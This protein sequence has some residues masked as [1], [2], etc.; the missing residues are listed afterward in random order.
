MN[1]DHQHNPEAL[2]KLYKETRSQS[3]TVDS[4]VESTNSTPDDE[5]VDQVYQR[6]QQTRN[7]ESN[8]IDEIMRGIADEERSAQIEEQPRLESADTKVRSIDSQVGPFSWLSKLS[9][10]RNDGTAL[11]FVLPVVAAAMCAFII[12]P[13]VSD[14]V[15]STDPSLDTA[16]LSPTLAPYVEPLNAS[17]LGFS[18]LN[19]ERGNAFQY[20]VLAADLQVLKNS[21]GSA[22]QLKMLVQSYLADVAN[23]PEEMNLAAQQIIALS[24]GNSDAATHSPEIIEGIDSLLGATKKHVANNNS[25]QW[26][27]LGQS[28]ESVVLSSRHALSTS[29]TS[30]LQSAMEH[31]EAIAVPDDSA[32]LKVLLND[33]FAREVSDITPA[34]DI[35]RILT[36]AED[37]KSV[38]Q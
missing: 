22:D 19:N 4:A 25:T 26:Y 23:S 16:Y 12:F 20:G 14:K 38:A 34:S 15:R 33:L 24:A 35:R 6:Y 13:L 29:D 18:D 30:V 7:T 2:Y 17:M 10:A 8:A 27:S 21:T 9:G 36:E 31:G 11:K 37:I 3:V 32:E 1:K 28:V 5:L